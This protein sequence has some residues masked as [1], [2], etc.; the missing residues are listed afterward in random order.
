[1]YPIFYTRIFSY[2]NIDKKYRMKFLAT[3]LIF[4]DN[5]LRSTSD[6]LN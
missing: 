6:T 1:M 2:K 3:F 5:I 4:S